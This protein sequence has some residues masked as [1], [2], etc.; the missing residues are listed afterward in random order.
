LQLSQPITLVPNAVNTPLF[1]TILY[2]FSPLSRIRHITT[3][4]MMQSY[5]DCW[6]KFPFLLLTSADI[7]VIG[8]T[9]GRGPQS[10]FVAGGDCPAGLFLL[11]T[12]GFIWCLNPAPAERLAGN[13]DDEDDSKS[14][15]F[16]ANGCSSFL[17][18]NEFE[19][20]IAMGEGISGL[21]RCGVLN[22]TGAAG[23]DA[24]LTLR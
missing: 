13:E 17:I 18:A 14:E 23:A 22:A 10:K 11:S 20:V 4:L 1:D 2:P 7:V 24:A 19:P 9:V 12:T 5:E 3:Y 16:H 6:P 21:G 8:M 15:S